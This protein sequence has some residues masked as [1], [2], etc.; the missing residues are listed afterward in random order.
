MLEKKLMNHSWMLFDV[1]GKLK[2][3]YWKALFAN[4]DH[5]FI[6]IQTVCATKI[7]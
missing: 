4:D 5:K 3:I 1:L 7:I 2:K 6:E